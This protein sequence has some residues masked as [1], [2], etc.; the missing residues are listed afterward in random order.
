MRFFL[1][2]IGVL[3]CSILFSQPCKDEF[4]KDKNAFTYFTV[5]DISNIS[6]GVYGDW[7]TNDKLKKNNII[8]LNYVIGCTDSEYFSIDNNID[9]IKSKVSIYGPHLYFGYLFAKVNFYRDTLSI[10]QAIFFNKNMSDINEYIEYKIFYQDSLKVTAQLSENF[11][12][13]SHKEIDKVLKK[14]RTTKDFYY[15]VNGNINKIFR[16]ALSGNEECKGI[17]AGA[18]S[19]KRE[20]T[21]EEHDYFHTLANAMKQYYKLKK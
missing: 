16:G 19:F 12:K 5:Y 11:K 9:T 8:R 3:Y 13:L 21:I 7:A 14:Y 18:R 4:Q 10:K 20:F 17:I 2:L 6:I 15:A 1:I